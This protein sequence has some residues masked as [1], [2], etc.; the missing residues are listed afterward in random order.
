[1]HDEQRQQRLQAALQQLELQQ[2]VEENLY[3]TQRRRSIK[4]AMHAS[5]DEAI[6][7]GADVCITTDSSYRAA[8]LQRLKNLHDTYFYK[9]ISI[10]NKPFKDE[11]QFQ[12]HVI[13]ILNMMSPWLYYIRQEAKTRSGIPDIVI[14]LNGRFVA[15]ELKDDIGDTSAQQ[16]KNLNKINDACGIGIKLRTIK[17]V[18][19]ALYACF[20]IIDF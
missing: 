7:Q 8:A 11:N 2:Q 16:N 5:Q 13:S 15:F 12:Q 14:C 3:D 1:M 19:Q 4:E 18:F 9:R 10:Y 20:G 17:Q 6:I